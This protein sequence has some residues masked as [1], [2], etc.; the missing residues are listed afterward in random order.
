ML[1]KVDWFYRMLW[2]VS[3]CETTGL[4]Y[5]SW[6]EIMP[7][8]HIIQH[9]NGGTQDCVCV[10][11]IQQPLAKKVHQISLLFSP[12]PRICFQ[13]LP[14]HFIRTTLPQLQAS[15]LLHWNGA[16]TPNLFIGCPQLFRR[17]KCIS[18]PVI[19]FEYLHLPI[20]CSV[21]TLIF[22]MSRNI[23]PIQKRLKE[24]KSKHQSLDLWRHRSAKFKFHIFKQSIFITVRHPPS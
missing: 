1:H 24:K 8:A 3:H 15:L 6:S 9:F 7:T 5:S 18:S 23:I 21:H 16:D 12:S 17:M 2:I 20:N 19:L 22:Y 11:F 13:N 10:G 14:S 4:S